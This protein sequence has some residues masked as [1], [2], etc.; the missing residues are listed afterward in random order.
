MTELE[1][2][3]AVYKAIEKKRQRIFIV[4]PLRIQVNNIY[5]PFWKVGLQI[6]GYGMPGL[7]LFFG[8]KQLWVR[9]MKFSKTVPLWRRWK[10]SKA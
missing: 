7:F 10:I 4:G 5:D 8:H 9:R 6:G 1:L 3:A 2:D